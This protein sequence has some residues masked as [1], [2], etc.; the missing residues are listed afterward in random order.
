MMWTASHRFDQ[1]ARQIADRH[2]NR[3]KIG[4]PQF[5]P[6]GRCLVLKTS[7]AFWVSSYPFAQYVRHA[8]R[9][10]WVCSAFRN[11]GSPAD[12]VPLIVEAL[13]L[14]RGTWGVPRVDTW[15]IRRRHD[16]SDV[17]RGHAAMVSFVD[18]S[19]TLPKH[20]PGKAYLRAGFFEIG[21]TKGGLVALGF[22]SDNL[23]DAAVFR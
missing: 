12:T 22:P 6:P 15:F 16:R 5:V 2:Y 8:W 4:S 19:K 3:Q 23:P 11:E 7:T 10:A 20:R 9:G 18:E 17:L 1:E 21:R 13:A 14:T